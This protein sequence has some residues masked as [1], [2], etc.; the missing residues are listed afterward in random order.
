[1]KAKPSAAMIGM[2]AAG[3]VVLAVAAVFYFGGRTWMGDRG[4]FVVYFDESVHGLDV[5]AAVKFRG[6]RLGRVK[7]VGIHYDPVR[8]RS[9]VPVVCELDRQIARDP[10]G[11]PV[12]LSDPELLRALVE[13]G[14]GARLTLVGLSGMMFIELDYASPEERARIGPVPDDSVLPAVPAVPSTLAGLREGVAEITA[15]VGEIDFAGIA[16]K[17]DG[18]LDQVDAKLDELDFA[19][20]GTNLNRA[21]DAVSDLAQSEDFFQAIESANATFADFSSLL[22]QLDEQIEPVSERI[23]VTADELSATLNQLGSAVEA[24]ETLVSPRTGVGAE[25]AATLNRLGEAARSVQRLA[26]YLERN[27]NALLS[28]RR[29]ASQ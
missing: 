28:G 9:L 7:N 17:F 6:V 27:P 3:A 23:T 13:R 8:G 2:F 24:I 14:L 29:E 5:G 25:L 26:D 19:E 21:A 4:E 15:N 22:R 1:M 10:E 18:L 16:R 12:D 20:L 11:N